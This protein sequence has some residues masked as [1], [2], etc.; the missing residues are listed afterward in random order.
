MTDKGTT[1]AGVVYCPKHPEADMHGLLRGAVRTSSVL[2]LAE[3][4]RLYDID[5]HVMWLRQGLWSESHSIAEIQATMRNYGVLLVCPLW[6]AYLG[7][8]RYQPMP[9]ELRVKVA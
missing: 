6:C 8:E 7:P 1:W 2:R 9:K 4:I 5:F 3:V